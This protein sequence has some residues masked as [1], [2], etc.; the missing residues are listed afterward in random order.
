MLGIFFFFFLWIFYFIFL[1][2]LVNIKAYISNAGS[3]HLFDA[4]FEMVLG[5]DQRKVRKATIRCRLTAS[6]FSFTDSN[7]FALFRFMLRH[8]PVHVSGTTLMIHILLPNQM[9][10]TLQFSLPS[11]PS[12]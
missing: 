1:I 10:T 7:I 5:E 12:N 11:P 3:R 6:K 9:E 8:I 2:D 4:I